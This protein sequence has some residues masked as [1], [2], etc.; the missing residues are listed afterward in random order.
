MTANDGAGEVLLGGFVGGFLLWVF[1]CS[2]L[3]SSAMTDRA[4]RRFLPL[5]FVGSC[6]FAGMIVWVA[7]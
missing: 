4:F 7:Q 3:G 2:M 1:L 5:S 6:A